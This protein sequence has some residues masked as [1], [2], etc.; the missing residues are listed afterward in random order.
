MQEMLE[1]MHGQLA[2]SS[3]NNEKVVPPEREVG[4][5][6]VANYIAYQM[7]EEISIPPDY[8]RAVT[9]R[10]LASAFDRLGPIRSRQD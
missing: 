3:Q 8:S 1:R 7:T 2:N 10:N 9:S 5:D 4:M 6:M